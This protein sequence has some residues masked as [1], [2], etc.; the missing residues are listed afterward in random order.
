MMK[1]KPDNFSENK[2]VLVRERKRHTARWVASAR[3]AFLSPDGGGGTP[4]QSWLGGGGLPPSSPDDRG[5]PPSSPDMGVPPSSRDGGYAHPITIGGYPIQS[6]P[7]PPPVSWM[8][9]PTLSAGWGYPPPRNFNRQTP[10]KT[11]PSLVLCTRAVKIFLDKIKGS[12]LREILPVH[13]AP[14]PAH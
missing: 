2:K 4:I 7:P 14:H 12:G 13:C 1:N 5:V 3:S 10:V 8:G 11:V 6:R 9:V